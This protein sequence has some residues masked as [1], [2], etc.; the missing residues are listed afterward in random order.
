MDMQGFGALYVEAQRD[1]AR[2]ANVGDA[3]ARYPRMAV[4]MMSCLASSAPTKFVGYQSLPGYG[5]RLVAD[6][7]RVSEL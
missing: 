2:A 6:G 7:A 1:R 5:Q 3:E 4:S